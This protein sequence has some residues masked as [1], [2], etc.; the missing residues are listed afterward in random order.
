MGRA[1]A[2]LIWLLARSLLSLAAPQNTTL[3]QKFN[4]GVYFQLFEPKTNRPLQFDYEVW[5]LDPDDMCR[6]SCFL[7]PP[8]AKRQSNFVP[9]YFR[10]DH[11]QLQGRVGFYVYD[12]RVNNHG[13]LEFQNRMCRNKKSQIAREFCFDEDGNRFPDYAHVIAS[14]WPLNATVART[15]FGDDENRG[16][17]WTRLAKR[18]PKFNN[19][20]SI[21]NEDTTYDNLSQTEVHAKIM[22][23]Y[24]PLYDLYY[25]TM[26]PIYMRYRKDV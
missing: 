12:L 1:F 18:G 3:L 25:E 13:V 16:E 11:H 6:N 14:M 2:M 22:P 4:S 17:W 19:G 15:Y 10:L 5:G 9:L 21:V 26:D 8:E 20:Y 23:H 24:R 7:M